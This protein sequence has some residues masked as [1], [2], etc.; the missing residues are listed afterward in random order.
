VI[1]DVP[2]DGD[3]PELVGYFPVRRTGHLYAHFAL[4][5][6]SL[7][8]EL[9]IAL[10]G[11]RFFR[12]ERDGIAFW[13]SL[14]DRSLVHWSDSMP[15]RL[16]EPAPFV[17]YLVDVDLDVERGT[18]ALRISE[19]GV[20]EPRVALEAQPNAAAQAGSAVDKFSF[21]GDRGSDVSRVVYYVDDIV[22]ASDGDV[23]LSP[24]VAPG[25]RSLFV[26]SLTRF[27]E[28]GGRRPICLPA[29]ALSDF[30]T[31][32]RAVARL[33]ERF[34]GANEDDPSLENV[35]QLFAALGEEGFAGEVGAK[36]AWDRGCNALIEGEAESALRAFDV[37][38]AAVPES[39][40][41]QSARALALA[42]A[43]RFDEADEY[44][45]AL[46]A[47]WRDD[48]RYPVLA[49]RLGAARG[50]LGAAEDS[51][52]RASEA[53]RQT[54]AAPVLAE[55]WTGE[56]SVEL[57]RAL[58]RQ[59][60][61]D[62]RDRLAQAL[63]PEQYFYVLLWQQQF[64]EAR[65]HALALAELLERFELPSAAW[66]ERAGDAAFH[67]GEHQQ[68]RALYQRSLEERSEAPTRLLLKL[69]DVCYQL[70]DLAQE[71]RLREAIY[72][73]LRAENR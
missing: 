32:P 20:T 50:D 10:A 4:L 71:R 17:W 55:V 41:Y 21:I 12:L 56:R 6:T 8:E 13:L 58:A 53:L 28:Y 68:A 46:G 52:V 33:R 66:R 18:Y 45:F 69:A 23:R 67:A 51:L 31:D 47:A 29:I 65:D 26:D 64:A 11:P 54:V 38:L 22:L 61:E 39:A 57:T 40:L 49:A 44:V 5:L 7:E 1:R 14:H 60:P 43:G 2:Q 70:G 48:P 73:S 25:R 19:E 72:G 9:N 24:F 34:A 16:F 62:W 30:V 27:R 36:Q 63:I 59:F 37:A 3:F 15:K 42:Q 35:E